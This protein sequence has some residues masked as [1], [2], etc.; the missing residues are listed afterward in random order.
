MVAQEHFAVV[1]EY[2]E[3]KRKS[4]GIEAKM[5]ELQPEVLAAVKQADG[6]L[7]VNGMKMS[8]ATRKKWEYPP[9]IT[10]LADSLK[11]AKKNAETDGEATATESEYL[12]CR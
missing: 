9:H 1:E 3:L 5:K 10:D 8:V 12:V 7:S 11:Q 6:E 2:A 4:K